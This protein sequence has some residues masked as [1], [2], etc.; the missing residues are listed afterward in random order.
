MINS[1]HNLKNREFS[2]NPHNS[3]RNEIKPTIQWAI[4]QT[5]ATQRAKEQPS[6]EEKNQHLIDDDLYQKAKEAWDKALLKKFH[7]RSLTR[8]EYLDACKTYNIELGIDYYYDREDDPETESTSRGLVFS[9][10]FTIGT[11]TADWGPMYFI[12]KKGNKFLEEREYDEVNPFSWGF[13]KVSKDWIAFF[14]DPQGNEHLK[15]R[16]YNDIQDFSEGY[17]VVEYGWIQF[18]INSEWE[19]CRRDRNYD[20]VWPFSGGYAVAK[21]D[22]RVFILDLNGNEL[23]KERGYEDIRHDQ[24]GVFVVTQNKKMFIINAQ[25]KEYGKEEGYSNIQ[26]FGEKGAIASKNLERFWINTK[27]ERISDIIYSKRF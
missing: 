3:K 12:D 4:A 18:C 23:F 25:G 20:Y 26:V 15:E 21:K 5:F 19:E 1:D 17:A 7:H 2:Q 6:I 24:N 11:E 27:G 8:A 14:V 16:A 13:A 22:G 9:E 10:E